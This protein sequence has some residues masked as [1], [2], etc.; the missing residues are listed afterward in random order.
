[1]KPIRLLVMVRGYLHLNEKMMDRL[2]VCYRYRGLGPTLIVVPTTVM[3]Q[4][5]KEFH[6]WAPEFRVA[7]LH[8]SGSHSSSPVSYTCVLISLYTTNAR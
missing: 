4:W 6:K 3:H 7:I 2:M 8:S 1:M 5:V